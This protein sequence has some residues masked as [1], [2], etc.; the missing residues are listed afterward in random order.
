MSTSPHRALTPRGRFLRRAVLIAL[1]VDILIL[2]L[3][4]V[5]HY[6]AQNGGPVGRFFDLWIW[7]ASEDWSLSEIAGYIQ[8]TTAAIL[9]LATAR[10]TK[11]TVYRIW[12]YLFLFL[13]ADDALLLHERIGKRVALFLH[14]PS[15]GDLRPVDLGELAVWGFA[16]AVLGLLL[17][18]SYLKTDRAYRRDSWWL[19]GA[20]ATL[21]FPAVILDMVDIVIWKMFGG[22]DLSFILD[23]VEAGGELMAM[24]L[25]LWVAVRVATRRSAL[26]DEV[27][28]K[29]GVSDVPAEHPVTA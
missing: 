21:A 22:A 14:F 5:A 29:A 10:A 25:M 17:L 20:T 11:S 24:T 4:I 8:L 16:G 19:L 2:V 27:D 15:I 9:L 18:R 6:T 13:V 26:G 3:S 12:A 23:D 7:D 28:A 1:V